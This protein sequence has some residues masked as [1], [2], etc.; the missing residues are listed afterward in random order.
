MGAH[1]TRLRLAVAAAAGVLTAA[2]PVLAETPAS[3]IEE[4][5]RRLDA[6][7]PQNRVL[8]NMEI[9]GRAPSGQGASTRRDRPSTTAS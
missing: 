2:Q 8:N 5:A 4:F 1:R 7:G 3:T 6:E 9:G